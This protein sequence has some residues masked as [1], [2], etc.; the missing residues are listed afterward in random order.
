[1]PTRFRTTQCDGCPKQIVWGRLPNGQSVPLDPVA[2]TYLVRP[3]SRGPEATRL[4]AHDDSA[5][6]AL[7]FTGEVMVSHFAT[8]PNADQFSRGGRDAGVE[9][10]ME[11][12]RAVLEQAEVAVRKLGEAMVKKCPAGWGFVTILASFGENGFSTYVANV[13]RASAISLLREMA[14]KIEREEAPWPGRD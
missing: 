9:D 14:D 7:G 4:N 13:E 10:G 6:A 8:C 11:K 2:A 5:R 12:P 3:S 1:M